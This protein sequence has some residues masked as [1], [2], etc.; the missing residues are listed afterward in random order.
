MQEIL[1]GALA[2]GARSTEVP[3]WKSLAG[4]AAAAAIALLFVVAGVWKITNPF[5]WS[6]MLEQLQ[7]WYQVS[8]PFTIALGIAE[9]FAGV[10]ILLPRFRRW[11]AVLA[12]VMLAVFMVYAGWNYSTLIGKECSCFPWV[13]R[14]IGPGFFV[15]DA[16]MLALAALAGFWAKPSHG[17][18]VAAV[19][20]GAIAVFAAVNLGVAYSRESGT[21]APAS[22]TA[23]GQP[24]R[25]DTGRVFLYFYDPMCMHCDQAAR[26]MARYKWASD[27]RRVAL[28]TA[29]PQ[30]AAQFLK[31]TGF[32]AVTS[33]DFESLKKTFPF[34]DP[35]FGVVLERGRQ[36]AAVRTFA[37]DE[38]RATLQRLGFVE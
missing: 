22:I 33:L 25:L 23:E 14:T 5:T 37:G 35:P 18:R 38:P 12:V 27:V 6:T 30:F 28:P 9:T 26:E 2:S 15:G 1:P 20:L 19:A 8:L 31:D 36:K 11:G 7:V 10:L 24:F 34:G 17:V 13:K 29:Q 16:V 32:Q 3:A 4:H 21:E